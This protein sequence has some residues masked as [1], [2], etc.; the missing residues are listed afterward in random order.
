MHVAIGQL[1]LSGQ[2]PL[3]IISGST[4]PAVR[5]H[6]VLTELL[7]LLVVNASLSTYTIIILYYAIQHQSMHV[8]QG[9]SFPRA[10]STQT[11]TQQLHRE[12]PSWRKPTYL[13]LLIVIPYVVRLE[14]NNISRI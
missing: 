8:D 12:N 3:L 7:D 4:F 13:I 9:S 2:G 14:Q 11:M 10:R 6:Y 1:Q 5:Y